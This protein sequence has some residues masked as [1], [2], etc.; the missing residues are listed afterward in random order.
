MRSAEPLLE[1]TPYVTSWTGEQEPRSALVE[2]AGRLA[3]PMDS[4]YDRDRNGVLWSRT[5]LRPGHGRP[6][7]GRVHPL[8]QRRAM[9]DLLC[10]VCAQP[11][12]RDEDG[13]LWLLPDFQDD[14]AGWPTR[15][16]AVEPPVCLGC[17]RVSVRY[18]P[19]LRKGAVAVRVRDS[20]VVGVY[21]ALYRPGPL[22]P[23]PVGVDTVAYDDPRTRW[24]RAERLVREL[25]D[26]TIVP[27]ET[28]TCG[29]GE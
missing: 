19:A 15:M 12:D 11:A 13:V 17:V 7:F 28:L 27:L 23:V 9:A 6:D 3:Y 24:V 10:Q 25:G 29:Q 5:P 16:A 22:G 14:W 4:L 8:R 21:G 2:R 26:S 18:C 1:V 20:T